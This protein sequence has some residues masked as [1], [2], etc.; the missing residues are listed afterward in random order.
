ML[1]KTAHGSYCALEIRYIIGL[2][3]SLLRCRILV[4]K[5]KHRRLQEQ[6]QSYSILFDS[7]T[8]HLDAVAVEAAVGVTVR[9]VLMPF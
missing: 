1:H 6:F 2:G 7:T 3:A 9:F 8:W 5:S 4:Q